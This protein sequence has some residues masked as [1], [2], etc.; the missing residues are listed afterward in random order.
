MNYLVVL[1]KFDFA[2]RK[3]VG[4]VSAVVCP[5]LLVNHPGCKSM[6]M[7]F[8]SS[9]HAMKHVKY[10]SLAG[11]VLFK[12]YKK[13]SRKIVL[14]FKVISTNLAIYTNSIGSMGVAL[15]FFD[16]LKPTVFEIGHFLCRVKHCSGLHGESLPNIPVPFL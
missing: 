11:N 13:R 4:I 1:P 14:I 6:H 7:I 2:V 3:C 5:P 8:I 12:Y 15:E 10:Q 16:M 9:K